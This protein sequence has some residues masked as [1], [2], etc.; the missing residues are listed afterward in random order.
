MIRPKIF[1]ILTKTALQTKKAIVKPGRRISTR[2]FVKTGY[3]SLL[4]FCSYKVLQG[5]KTIKTRKIFLD[6][7][8]CI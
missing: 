7:T 8:Q 3:G 4:C 6:L 5:M 2:N 1:G